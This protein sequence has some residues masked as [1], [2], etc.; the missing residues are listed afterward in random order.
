MFAHTR[1]LLMGHDATP[2]NALRGKPA[3][4]AHVA[5]PQTGLAQTA[6]SRRR[7]QRGGRDIT[8]FITS[9]MTYEPIHPHRSDAQSQGAQSQGAQ[10]QGGRSSPLLPA[11][12][13][14]EVLCL[15]YIFSR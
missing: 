9:D 11:H 15:R 1:T 5:A 3:G 2:R 4:S 10:S 13:S 8:I 12:S 14:S 6:G 7:R